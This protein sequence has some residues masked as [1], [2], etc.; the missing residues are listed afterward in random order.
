[1]LITL[2]C[3]KKKKKNQKKR[4]KKNMQT[5]AA[6][7]AYQVRRNYPKTEFWRIGRPGGPA[8]LPSRST[9]GT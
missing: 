1:M 7:H 5:P 9:I 8:L 3:K 2:A 4:V 6:T